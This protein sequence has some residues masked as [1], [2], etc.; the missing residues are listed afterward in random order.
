MLKFRA[1]K[2]SVSHFRANLGE[3]IERVLQGRRTYVQRGRTPVAAL[4]SPAD[5]RCLNSL[6]VIDSENFSKICG[7]LTS[8][9][10]SKEERHAISTVQAWR[11]SHNDDTQNVDDPENIDE[12]V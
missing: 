8:K 2:V 4:V 12:D 1:R 3:Y 11:D 7:F 10:K 9:S 6:A 5:L